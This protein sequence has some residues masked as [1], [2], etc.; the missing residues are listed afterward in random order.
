M[1][2]DLQKILLS[3]VLRQNRND[4]TSPTN[5]FNL[6]STAVQA[7]LT[8]KLKGILPNAS[9][10][11]TENE[12][13]TAWL[14]ANSGGGS[15]TVTSVDITTNAGAITITGNPITTAGAID[16][17]FNGANTDYIDG[18]GNAQPFPTIPSGTVTSVAALTLGTS[19]TDLSSTVANPTTTP[20]IT[21]NV[22][23]ASASNRG[24]LSAADWAVFNNKQDKSIVI[25]SNTTAV[26]DGVYTVVASATFTDPTPA[27]GK[28]FM[29]FVR[30]GTATVGGTGYSTAGT[31]INRIYHS[32]AWA[33]Y[34]L[35]PT[36]LAIGTTPITGGTVGRV[37]FEGSGNVLQ[38][39]A[40]LNL[41]TTNGL[42]IGG[43]TARGTRLTIVNS[44]DSAAVQNLIIRNAADSADRLIVYGDGNIKSLPTNIGFN[45][46]NELQV[47]VENTGITAANVGLTFKGPNS[48]AFIANNQA[49]T[50]VN[51]GQIVSGAPQ[52]VLS[53]RYN[54]DFRAA[55]VRGLTTVSASV[56]LTILNAGSSREWGFLVGNT[57]NAVL[58]TGGLGLFDVTSGTFGL[59]LNGSTLNVGVGSILATA[60]LHIRA[61]SA[62]ASTAPLK[63]TTGTIL[64]TAEAGAMEYNNTFHLTNSDATRRHVVTAPNTTKVTAGAPYANDGYIVMN[65]GGT[66]FK[67]MTTA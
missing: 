65:I 62:T 53:F 33:N 24:A 46:S 10:N 56:G 27:E 5:A 8:Q 57:S 34:T 21:L 38:E 47:H 66:D 31:V 1:A 51:I 2:S 32:G 11:I 52:Y 41:D 26:L 49:L 17:D 61:G 36:S 40:I 35:A 30:N 23:T 42:I 44:S 6:N 19:G 39:N 59:T 45:A 63:F 3:T 64:T 29:V 13:M 60:R 48:H 18:E 16:L 7:Y 55:T 28:G 58:G 4:T 12:L 43:A 14:L 15:G 50:A 9:G 54:N 25:N 37:L 20:V 67:I 22:P